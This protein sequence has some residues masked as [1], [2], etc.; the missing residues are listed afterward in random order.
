MM[1]LDL[2]VSSPQLDQADRGFSFYQDGPLDMRMNQTQTVT[3][4]LIVNTAT[5]ADLIRIFKD[6]GEIQNPMRVVRAILKDREVKAFQSTLQ[7][8]GMIERVDGWRKKGHHPATLYFQG[9]RLAVN[10][11]LDVLKEALPRFMQALKPG[12]RLAVISFHSLEDRVVKWLFKE[13]SFGFSVHNK[14]IEASETETKSNPRARSAKLRI[15]QKY[16]KGVQDELE[17]FNNT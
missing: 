5:E 9:L 1:L 4:E 12:G 10:H 15:F 13:S 6:Y 16:I 2:G 7:L 8:A 11:E 14:V 3:A 17:E